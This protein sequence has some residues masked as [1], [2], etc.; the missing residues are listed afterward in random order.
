MKN[1]EEE[2]YVSYCSLFVSEIVMTEWR[3]VGFLIFPGA[4]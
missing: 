1:A 3:I 2:F 4:L